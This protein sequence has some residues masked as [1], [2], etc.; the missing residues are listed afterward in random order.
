MAKSKNRGRKITK[1]KRRQN[2]TKR[3]RRQLGRGLTSSKSSKTPVNNTN[4]VKRALSNMQVYEDGKDTGRTIPLDTT[5]IEQTNDPFML[6]DNEEFIGPR[7]P[8][9]NESIDAT[10]LR[11]RNARE[12]EE[13]RIRDQ[14][15]RESLKV[16]AK[17]YSNSKENTPDWIKTQLDAYLKSKGK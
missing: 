12:G 1:R 6:Q 2:Y 13:K 7:A 14:K 3:R 8:S 4:A 15:N 10:K 11:N 17:L 16:Y 5:R 9:I